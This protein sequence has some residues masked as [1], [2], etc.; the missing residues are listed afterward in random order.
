MCSEHY[1]LTAERERY[2]TDVPRRTP[3]RRSEPYSATSTIFGRRAPAGEPIAFLE[4]HV[5][6][7]KEDCLI[8]PFARYENGYGAIRHQDRQT[9]AHRVMCKLAHGN[10]PE[11]W[12]EASHTCENGHNGCVNPRHLVWETHYDNHQ[13][14]AGRV[15][16]ATGERH[17]RAK[18]TDEQVR[19]IRADS[20]KGSD[21][22]R[23]YGVVKS[24][25]SQI[26]SGQKR[27]A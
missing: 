8:W 13:R 18:L 25:I 21:I 2:A 5:E 16:P 22:A 26:R 9:I 10:P 14:R 4:A 3:K 12:F 15:G 23:E 27:Q 1:A 6:V 24:T 17:P 7:R 19:A 20:R 11:P